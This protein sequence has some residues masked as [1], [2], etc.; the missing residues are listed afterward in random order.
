MA[1]FVNEYTCLLNM[2][3]PSHSSDSSTPLTRVCISHSQPKQISK[4]WMKKGNE[5]YPAMIFQDMLN[6]DPYIYR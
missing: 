2:L 1:T 3:D 4:K 6:R 5:I